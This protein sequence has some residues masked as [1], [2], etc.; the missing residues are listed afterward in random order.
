MTDVGAEDSRSHFEAISVG[1]K[2]L[3]RFERG[4][5]S[6]DEFLVDRHW[7]DLMNYLFWYC[8]ELISTIE[9]R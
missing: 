5:I 2:K 1:G 4:R 7:P 8:D 9:I 3:T 6:R